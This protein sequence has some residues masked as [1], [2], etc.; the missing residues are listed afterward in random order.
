MF[1]PI[2]RH[3]RRLKRGFE[4]ARVAALALPQL[5]LLEVSRPNVRDASR[6]ARGA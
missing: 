5:S 6:M 3:A 4:G 2:I 1:G